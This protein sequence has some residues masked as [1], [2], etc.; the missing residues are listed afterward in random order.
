M[1]SLPR[2]LSSVAPNSASLSHK[3]ERMTPTIIFS[4]F[5]NVVVIQ[6]NMHSDSPNM[7]RDGQAHAGA[8]GRLV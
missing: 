2:L 6:P 7:S 3:P 5:P 1:V 4:H 8:K